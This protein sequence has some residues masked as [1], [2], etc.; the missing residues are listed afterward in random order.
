MQATFS[1]DFFT[2]KPHVYLVCS[3]WEKEFEFHEFIQVPPLRVREFRLH[4]KLSNV[5]EISIENMNSSN[6]RSSITLYKANATNNLLNQYD[7]AQ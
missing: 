6:I 5:R 3:P 2:S 7:T 1:L 4:R